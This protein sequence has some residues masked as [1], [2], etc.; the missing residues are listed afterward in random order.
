MAMVVAAGA[1]TPWQMYLQADAVVKTVMLGLAVA[2]LATW[3]VLLAK[4]WEL[5]GQRRQVQAAIA[6]LRHA[7][8][9]PQACTEPALQ[10][11]VAG[12]LLHAAQDELEQSADLAHVQGVAPRLASRLHRIELAALRRWRVGTGVLATVGAVAPF[13]G[14]FGTVWGIMNSFVG[15]AASHSSSLAVVAPGIAEALLATAMGL[16][17]AIPAVVIYNHLGRRITVLRAELGDASAALQQRV[18]RELD[19]PSAERADAPA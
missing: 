13:V 2:S 6:A 1:L 5:R 19:R 10:Q 15:I 14:L 18:S 11:G 17:A 4:Q 9:W 12:Q 7:R 8:D 3:T 16:V